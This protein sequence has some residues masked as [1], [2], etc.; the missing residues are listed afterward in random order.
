MSSAPPGK[1]A[2]DVIVKAVQERRP[3]GPFQDLVIEGDV[4]LESSNYFFPLALHGCRFTGRFIA[5]GAVLI[6]LQIAV[7]RG[8]EWSSR[9][10]AQSDRP[11][12]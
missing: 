9:P 12:T 11:A 1:I 6:L 5:A 10:L 2:A 7:T 3:I 4:H 8:V